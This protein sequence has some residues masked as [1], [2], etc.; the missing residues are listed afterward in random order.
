MDKPLTLQIEE[1]KNTM[2][3]TINK[4]NIHPYIIDTVLK[5]L[6]NEVHFAYQNQVTKEIK[7]YQDF[8]D[9]LKQTEENKETD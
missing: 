4:S 3:E 2:V 7:E 5:N 1:F 8:V 9:K 6:Y